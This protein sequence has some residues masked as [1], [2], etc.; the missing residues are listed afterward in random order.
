MKYRDDPTRGYPRG[1]CGRITW[2]CPYD[3]TDPMCCQYKDH[4]ANFKK[5]ADR[6]YLSDK[7]WLDKEYGKTE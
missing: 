1:T 7:D 4:L 6:K 3:P 2:D 5:G